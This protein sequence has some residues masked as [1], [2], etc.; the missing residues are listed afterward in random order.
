MN[1]R[2][3]QTPNTIEL[4]CAQH[5]G[6]DR[7]QKSE[8]WK[9]IK[10]VREQDVTGQYNN[11]QIC[12]NGSPLPPS[13]VPWSLVLGVDKKYFTL[14]TIQCLWSAELWE[15]GGRSNASSIVACG[16]Y[17]G[18]PNNKSSG[19]VRWTRAVFGVNDVY[20]I[21]KS[22][23]QNKLKS[24]VSKMSNVI[25]VQLLNYQTILTVSYPISICTIFLIDWHLIKSVIIS[26]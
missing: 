3:T 2:T 22:R 18:R 24:D 26:R 15:F 13:G 5:F 4:H 21:F 7:R 8:N 17:T 19:G 9:N 16:R 11:R 25:G 1:G 6:V 20:V 10:H 23:T 14:F 12:L